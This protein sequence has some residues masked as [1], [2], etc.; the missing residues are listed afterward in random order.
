[1]AL[2][3][4]MGLSLLVYSLAEK[5]LRKVMAE[6]GLSVPDQKG[7]PASKPTLRWIFQIFEGI[8]VLYIHKKNKI[9][10]I[11]TN[12]NDNHILVIKLFGFYVKKMYFL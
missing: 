10:R 3:M 2:I 1:M 8:I 7:K 5:K 6:S 9:T 11:A 4:V 12:I